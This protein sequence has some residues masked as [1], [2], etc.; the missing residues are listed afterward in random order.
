M[1]RPSSQKPSAEKQNDRPPD[2]HESPGV[3]GGVSYWVISERTGEDGEKDIFFQV[4]APGCPAEQQQLKDDVERT[5]SALRA[6]YAG[7]TAKFNEAFAKLLALA[8]VGLPGES[9]ATSVARA[10]L[11]SLK[12][13]VVDQEAGRIKNQY[14]IKLGSWAFAVRHHCVRDLCCDE[15]FGVGPRL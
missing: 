13:E 3:A 1:N 9:P 4:L 11:D 5:L 6:I 8:Q 12:A 14:M 7:E 15:T 2:E 10:A